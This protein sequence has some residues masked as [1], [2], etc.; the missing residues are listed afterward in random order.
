MSRINLTDKKEQIINKIKKAKTDSLPI[1]STVSE[2]DQRPEARNLI[3]IYSSLTDTSLE[4]SIK[5]FAGKNFSEF[6]ENLS[7]VLVDKICPISIEIE[8]LL[9]E[10]SYL[11]QIL[12][13]GCQKAN[14]IAS[15][16]IEK[17]HNIVGF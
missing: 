14:N 3:S 16:K 9:N 8:K 5:I 10:K 1:P 17:L 2:L 15:K 4:K 13:D 6:K 7:E 11:D 12:I